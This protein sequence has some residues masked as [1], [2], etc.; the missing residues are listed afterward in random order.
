MTWEHVFIFVAGF[1]LGQ[2]VVVITVLWL[3]S[4]NDERNH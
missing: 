2:A 1:V 3:G 4:T